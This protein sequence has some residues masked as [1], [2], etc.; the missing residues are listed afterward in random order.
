MSSERKRF[1]YPWSKS[2][3]CLPSQDFASWDEKMACFIDDADDSFGTDLASWINM[4]ITAKHTLYMAT[5]VMISDY[6][7]VKP[8]TEKAQKG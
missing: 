7:N 2:A 1:D 8:E 3:P 6:R 4:G 5:V